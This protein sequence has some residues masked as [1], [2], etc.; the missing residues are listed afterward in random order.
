L[1]PELF[2]RYIVKIDSIID[3]KGGKEYLLSDTPFIKKKCS[4][5][6]KELLAHIWESEDAFHR[7]KLCD[8]IW[9]FRKNCLIVSRKDQNLPELSFDDLLDNKDK[10]AGDLLRVWVDLLCDIYHV[11]SHV[12]NSRKIF[13]LVAMA[14]QVIDDMLDSP[15]DYREGVSNIFLHILEETVHEFHVAKAH[16][17]Q[18]TYDYLDWTWANKYLPNTCKKAINRITC[19]VKDIS[20]LSENLIMTTELCAIIEEWRVLNPERQV[21]SDHEGSSMDGGL[22]PVTHLPT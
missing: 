8:Q 3:R 19:Y 10:T 1:I 9:I 15:V 21:D 20:I 17:E 18:N 13:G 6:L 5:I 11:S 4:D 2:I 12:E 16:F 14:I 22:S 7:K